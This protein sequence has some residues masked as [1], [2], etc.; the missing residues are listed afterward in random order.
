MRLD[1]V[2]FHKGFIYRKMIS[3]S[4]LLVSLSSGREI[5][6]F[7][8]EPYGTEEEISRCHPAGT[9]VLPREFNPMERAWCQN[10]ALNPEEIGWYGPFFTSGGE[11]PILMVGR[12]VFDRR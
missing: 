2:R 7:T 9:K 10:F 12:G 11:L 3:P 1:E 6:P 5:N 4:F 8:D